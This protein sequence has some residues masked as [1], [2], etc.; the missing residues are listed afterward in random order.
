MAMSSDL[1]HLRESEQRFR[2]LF[3]NNPDLVL[4]QNGEGVILDAN[5]TYL[6]VL[7]RQK[8]QVVG[9]PLNDFIP[10]ELRPLFTQKLHEAIAGHKV[11]FD[12]EVHFIGASRALM[13]SITKVPLR[14]EG[15][16]TGVHVVCRDVTELFA[17]HQVIRDQAQKLSTIFESITDAFFLIDREWRCT[18]VNTEVERLLKVRRENLVGQSI[19]QAF[20][21]EEKGVFHEH[22]QR[23]LETGQAVHFEAYFKQEGLWLDVKAFPS[24]EGLSVYFS[25]V[26]EKVRS[27]GELYRQN[28][29]LQQFTYIVSHNLRA[30]L[31]NAMGLVDLLTSLDQQTLDY[32]MT[33]SNLQVS[34][35]Q[36][37]AVLRDMNTILSIRDKQGVDGGEPVPLLDVVEQARLN[38]E[39]S[40]A[41]IGGEVALHI[42]ADLSVFGN[43]AYL[44]SIFFNLLS[45]AV[46]YRAD[47][48]PLR[49]TVMATP[50]PGEGTRVVVADNGSGF[51]QD[52][53]GPDVF[54]LYKR[55][56]NRQPGRGMGLYLVKTHVETM[57]GHIELSSTVNVGTQ[58]IIQL[59]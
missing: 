17:S 32:D 30:P 28:K 35:G 58:F 15:A 6:Q 54:R 31:A 55:F 42:P 19:W 57:G 3:E 34:I 7:N 8:E 46:K 38:L 43:R 50:Q 45:N 41:Q 25:D 37:D 22:Y 47:G 36:L 33:M 14:V 10:E 11:Q 49:V 48:R 21:E 5:P 56:H 59:R 40:I 44:Y 12:V 1:F 29:D 2:A 4:F 26:T 53:A 18:Y 16:I 9:R 39:E 27:Q 23:A 13:L 24:R 51:D 52:K 20:P